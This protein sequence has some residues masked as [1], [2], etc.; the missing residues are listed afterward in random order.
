[1][2]K[3]LLVLI[4]VLGISSVANAVL[5]DMTVGGT[6][7]TRTASG[8]VTLYVTASDSGD[9]AKLGDIDALMTVTGGDVISGAMNLSDCASYGWDVSLSANPV[10][11]GTAGV[12]MDGGMAS[13]AGTLGVVGYVT[14]AYTMGNKDVVTVNFSEYYGGSYDTNFNEVMSD[15]FS[16]LGGVTI[17]PEPMTMALLGLGGLFLRRRK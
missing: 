14:I 4:L 15:S 13:T 5:V 16:T 2:M 1:M 7:I 11:L 6:T 8:S 9:G 3:K 17:I 12:Q 10:G